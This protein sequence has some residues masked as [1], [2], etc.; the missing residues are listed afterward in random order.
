MRERVGKRVVCG[1]WRGKVGIEFYMCLCCWW[2]QVVVISRAG[3]NLMVLA[4]DWGLMM[5]D[6]EILDLG[7]VYRGG[8]KTQKV[9]RS[10]ENEIFS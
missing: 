10:L 1:E 6:W 5:A 2:M 7:F 3:A 9:G 8:G 4:P